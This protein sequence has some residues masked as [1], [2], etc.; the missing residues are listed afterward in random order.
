[1]SLEEQGAYRNLL[2]EA[3]LRGGAIPADEDVLAKACGDPRRW[4]KVRAAVMARFERRDDGYH[5]Q[6]LDEVL[7]ESRKRSEKQRRYRNG[8]G[9]GGGN[10]DGNGGSHGASNDH[11]PPDPDPVALPE[12]SPGERDRARETVTPIASGP[13]PQHPACGPTGASVPSFLHQQFRDRLTAVET[14]ADTVLRT[15]YR[16]VFDQLDTKNIVGQPVRFWEQHFEIFVRANYPGMVI[17][18]PTVD[19]RGTARRSVSFAHP[20]DADKFAGLGVRDDDVQ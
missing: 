8:S 20:A 1:M 11:R 10:D 9:N 3:A 2:D 6:T 17:D 18:G 16:R 15:L 19:R 14:D 5:N 4:A 13:H 7:A 12:R